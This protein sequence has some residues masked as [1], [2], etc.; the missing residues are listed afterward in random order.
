[1]MRRDR[2]GPCTGTGAAR[3]VR[4]G[5]LIALVAVLLAAAAEVAQAGPVLTTTGPPVASGTA[6]ESVAFNPKFPYIAVVDAG[7]GNVTT[8]RRSVNGLLSLVDQA[9]TEREPTAATFRPDGRLL[10]V[11]NRAD[12]NLSVYSVT[13]TGLLEQIGR[14]VAAGFQPISMAFTPDGRVLATASPNDNSVR[15]FGVSPD[16]VLDERDKETDFQYPASVSFGRDGALLAVTS[17]RADSIRMYRVGPDG[18]MT[19]LGPG[20]SIPRPKS[21]VFD[22]GGGLL[23]AASEA[24]DTVWTY[25]V[26]QDGVLTRAPGEGNTGREPWSIAFAPGGR[27]LATA[28]R[29]GDSISVFSVA[30]DGRL[31][32]A[33]RQPTA[34]PGPTSVSFSPEGGLVAATNREAGGVA[35]FSLS[36][37]GVLTSIGAPSR[38][39]RKPVSLAYNPQG[40]SLAVANRIPGSVSLFVSGPGG[41]LPPLP[42]DVDTGAE[43]LGIAFNPDGTLAATADWADSTISM[44][45]VVVDDRLAPFAGAQ[46]Q[47]KPERGPFALAF[48]RVRDLLAT[49]DGSSDKVSLFDVSAD[50][51]LSNKRVAAAPGRPVSVA[52]DR[53][54]G[55]LATANAAAGSFSLFEVTES[56]TLKLLAS[57]ATGN[58]PHAIAFSPGGTL[59]ATA[60]MNDDTVRVFRVNPDHTVEPAAEART[61][62]GPISVAF[63]PDGRLLATANSD[64]DTASLFIV[65]PDGD[66]REAGS[67]SPTGDKPHSVAF[68]PSGRSFATANNEDDTVS[69]FTLAAPAL[70]AWITSGPPPATADE[71]ATFAFDSNYPATFACRIDDG[72]FEPCSSPF[73]TTLA[74]GEHRFTVRA[75]DLARVASA[76]STA[77]TWRIDR[78]P[79]AEV[80]LDAPPA[81]APN[82]PPSPVFS[83]SPA[84]DDATGVAAYE[85]LIDGKPSRQVAAG[86]CGVLCASTPGV[87]LAD[88]AHSWQVR[89]V[90][91]VG[92]AS[93]PTPA[94][95]FTVDATAPSPF[96][97]TSPKDNA[98]T[99]DRRPLLSWQGTSDGGIGLAGYDVVLDGAVVATLDASATTFTPGGDLAEAP[100]TWQVVARDHHGNARPSAVA[101]FAVDATAP[102]ARLAAAPATALVGRDVTFDAGATTDAGSG[103]ARYE[104]NLDGDD[105]FERGTGAAATTVR[106]FA[107]PGTFGVQVRVTD[108]AGLTAIARIDAQIKSPAGPRGSLGISLDDGA[109]Y[110]NTPKVTIHAAW[111]MLARQMIVS[112]DGGF[113]RAA[114][115]PLR[116]QTPWTLASSGPERLPKTV[117]VRFVGGLFV[118]ETYSDEIILDERDPTIARARLV[119][120]RGAVPVLRLKAKD[121]GSG[122]ARVQVTNNRLRPGAKFRRYRATVRLT[123]LRGERP[124]RLGRPVYVRVRDRAGNLS[125]WFASRR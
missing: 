81:G 61:G 68:H 77:A 51:A 10:V 34:T 63:S 119:V 92:N 33:P 39:G 110:T 71:T 22:P 74:E 94:R 20:A 16:G 106:S 70:D 38:T 85:L 97:V 114:A 18:T 66:L 41:E 53:D 98:A 107:E 90:D 73:T 47:P 89:A 95:A 121:R 8:Y 7:A 102:S 86:L 26:S 49:A 46:A 105:T 82:L 123:K 65:A 56:R 58:A 116:A 45:Q 36:E 9:P 59:L 31:A 75:T 115:F 14:P 4:N 101:H 122:V 21:V 37:R 91:G 69:V 84:A 100:H 11:A 88:G 124:L 113:K 80:Q 54:A 50:G 28:N 35:M 108:R 117:R 24:T 30:G 104:W 27:L 48:S 78:T 3:V 43:P 13:A 111:P 19:K 72:P 40:G 17:Q 67:P 64:G 44:F 109:V 83:W 55:L 125:R 62:A 57:P 93:V 6:P 118:S 25:R 120:K 2:G 103:I 76:T 32:P 1:M 29:A 23:A 52:F 12:D 42:T 96:A 15:T 5:A 99:T 60:N 79:P 87:A 112:N